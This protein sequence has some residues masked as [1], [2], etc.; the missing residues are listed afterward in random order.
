MK[1][2]KFW[3]IVFLLTTIY[4]LPNTVYAATLSLSPATGA[5]NRDC[6]FNLSVNVDTAGAQTDGT[7]AILIFDTS[8]FAATSVTNGTI[9]PDYPGNNIDSTAGKVFISGL[10]SISQPFTGTGTLAT[11]NFTVK[12]NAALGATQIK[13]DFNP[14]DKAKTDDSNV[15][16]RTTIVDI[17]NSVTDSSFTIGSGTTCAAGQVGTPGGPGQGAPGDASGSGTIDTTLPPA[18]TQSLTA[19]LAIVGTVLTILGILGLVLL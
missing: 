11:V 5:F 6:S 14:I 17:L 12:P 19:A 4:L 1:S 8:R 7:D 2:I 10:S 16:E 3:V 15:V 13:F 18:G 9:Y